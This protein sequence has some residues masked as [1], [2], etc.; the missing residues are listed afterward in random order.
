MCK[1]SEFLSENFKFLVVNFSIYFYRRVFVMRHRQ[2]A[3]DVRV[4]KFYFMPW[5]SSTLFSIP[6]LEIFLPEDLF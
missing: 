1:I 3:F 5:I 6:F 4:M 2:G